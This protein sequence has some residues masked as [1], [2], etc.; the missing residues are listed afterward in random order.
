[1]SFSP[2]PSKE[3]QEVIFIRK[4]NKDFHPSLTFNNNIGYQ[5]TSQNHLGI[6]VDNCLSFEEHLRLAF[7]KINKTIGLLRKLQSLIPRSASLTICKTFVR[8][9]PY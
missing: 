5:S 8:P 6:T 2:N 1:M 3:A 9:H 7:S 4:V